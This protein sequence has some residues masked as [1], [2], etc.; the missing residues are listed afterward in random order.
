MSSIINSV[1]MSKDELGFMYGSAGVIVSYKKPTITCLVSGYICN[2]SGGLEAWPKIL[3]KVSWYFKPKSTITPPS[4]DDIVIKSGAEDGYLD[5]YWAKN[6]VR[7]TY[8]WIDYYHHTFSLRGRE[9]GNYDVDSEAVV[10][11]K[12]DLD[13]D[14]EREVDEWTAKVEGERFVF[15]K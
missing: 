7:R 11:A 2:Y 13:G 5:S 14:G 3:N 12:Y 4:G 6:P 8:W 15:K 1:C 9:E 10:V